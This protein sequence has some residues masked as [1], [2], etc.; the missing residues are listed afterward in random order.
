MRK[1]KEVILEAVRQVFHVC[2]YSLLDGYK[3]FPEIL[4]KEGEEFFFSCWNNVYYRICLGV[5]QHPNFLPTVEQIEVGLNHPDHS[6]KQVYELRKDEW[7]AKIE[8]NKLKSCY[9]N[10]Y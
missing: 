9:F 10:N 6:V 3:T 7:L 2:S 8:G 4:E 1:D 5:A